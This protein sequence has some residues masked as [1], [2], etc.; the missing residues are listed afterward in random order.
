M[1]L[2]FLK[3]ASPDLAD[4]ALLNPSGSDKTVTEQH[5]RSRLQRQLVFNGPTE[6]FYSS[7]F[8]VFMRLTSPARVSRTS[9]SVKS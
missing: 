1:A 5:R 4:L 8:V 6:N 2:T 7:S 9:I 3:N